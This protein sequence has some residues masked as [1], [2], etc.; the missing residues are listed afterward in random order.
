MP[1]YEVTEGRCI[2]DV[3]LTPTRA[4]TGHV[5]IDGRWTTVTVIELSKQEIADWERVSGEY[6][7]WAR[8]IEEMSIAARQAVPR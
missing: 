1:K 7:A 2:L 3:V 8:R 5:Q 6:Y 4:S